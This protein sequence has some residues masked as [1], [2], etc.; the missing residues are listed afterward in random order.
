[1]RMWMVDVKK[2]C[3]KHL[4]G[5]HVQ[6]HMF[7]GT[8]NKGKCLSGYFDNKLLCVEKLKERHDELAN[9][10]VIRG[11]NHKSILPDFKILDT[12]KNGKIFVELNE[13]E[14]HDRCQRCKF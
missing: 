10:M 5:E 9:E 6:C 2:M 4:L 11:M 12:H 7:V 14:L 13:K 3:N 1:M 8:I